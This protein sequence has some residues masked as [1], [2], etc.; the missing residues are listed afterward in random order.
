MDACPSLS[1]NCGAGAGRLCSPCRPAPDRL[2]N[3]HMHTL[4]SIILA[5]P[6]R[7]P[8]R[9]SPRRPPWS[10]GRAAACSTA[11]PP[12]A[13]HGG[14]RQRAPALALRRPAGHGPRRARNGKV[15]ALGNGQASELSTPVPQARQPVERAAFFMPAQRA[16]TSPKTPPS[17]SAAAR[18]SR[19]Q[20]SGT[21][22]GGGAG[23]MADA[24]SRR[25]AAKGFRR[26]EILQCTQRFRCHE[27]SGCGCWRGRPPR[28]SRRRAT[29][30]LTE[31]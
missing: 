24:Q 18:Q 14:G 26:H 6:A 11:A 16:C 29:M 2:Y 28:C 7:K 8:V 20:A 23:A 30:P 15:L 5:C 10:R 17:R 21:T 31:G 13:S 27:T 1:Q 22:G 4:R 19:S 12:A 25:N 3:V 9:M